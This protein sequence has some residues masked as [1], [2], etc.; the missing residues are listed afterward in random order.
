M[1]LQLE[2]QK[3]QSSA[4]LFAGEAYMTPAALEQ[5]VL[6]Q[7][8]QLDIP[9][10]TQ[11]YLAS[12]LEQTAYIGEQLTHC[13]DRVGKAL[14]KTAKYADRFLNAVEAI[15]KLAGGQIP[16]ASLADQTKA[17]RPWVN[18]LL[19]IKKQELTDDE[20]SHAAE[21][22]GQG[23]GSPWG[24]HLRDLARGYLDWQIDLYSATRLNPNKLFL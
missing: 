20:K 15:K 12:S 22:S 17:L 3:L 10:S 6:N 2:L 9:L 7:Q 11:Q 16:Q 19:A 18:E 24:E 5:V 8:M 1:H 13:T 14:W 23:N 4:L 21:R